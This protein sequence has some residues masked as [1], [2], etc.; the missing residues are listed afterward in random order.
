MA[1]QL[2]VES[3]EILPFTY[4]YFD[5]VDFMLVSN[6]SCHEFMGALALSCQEDPVSLWHFPTS[7]SYSLP[8]PSS[9]MLFPDSCS[10]ESMI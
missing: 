6:Y 9:V 2:L 8:L 1:L 10:E 4:C 5:W 3:H 7:Y